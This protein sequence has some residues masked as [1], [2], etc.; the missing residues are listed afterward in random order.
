MS[1]WRPDIQCPD[2]GSKDIQFIELHYEMSV[3]I[4]NTCG[5]RF[6]IEED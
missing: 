3:Y 4:C 5:C 6:E 1:D 2:C